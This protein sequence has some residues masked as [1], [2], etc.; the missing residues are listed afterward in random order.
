[1]NEWV[2]VPTTSLASGIRWH[3]HINTFTEYRAINEWMNECGLTWLLGDCS[4]CENLLAAGVF[5][6]SDVK[7]GP[8]HPLKWGVSEWGGM[9]WDGMGWDGA[10]E[11]GGERSDEG[12]LPS[13]L[14]HSQPHSRIYLSL[15][16]SFLSFLSF[17]SNADQRMD[18][19]LSLSLS[20]PLT[21]FVALRSLLRR[22]EKT[23]PLL[24][25]VLCALVCVCVCVR[26]NVVSAMSGSGNFHSARRS[27]KMMTDVTVATNWKEIER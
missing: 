21:L 3:R 27:G 7:C 25:W 1:M 20:H 5:C 24:P 17:C 9:G 6:K 4:K 12:S 2:R 11:R 22:A 13:S 8:H 19:L 26:V 18:Q 14:T 15:Y 10:G 16:L 23:P